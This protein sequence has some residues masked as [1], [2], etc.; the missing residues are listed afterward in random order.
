MKRSASQWLPLLAL[1]VPLVAHTND[2]PRELTALVQRAFDRTLHA[3]GVRSLELHV[4]RNGHL[5]SRRAFDLAYRRDASSARSLLRFTAPAYLRGHALLVIGTND[6]TS[7]TWLYQAEERRPRRIAATHKA[8]SFYGSDLSFE[9]LEHP[10]FEHWSL[11]LLEPEGDADSNHVVVEATPLRESQYGKL[12]VWIDRSREAVARVDFHRSA[13]AAPH[14]R[15]RISLDDAAEEDGFLRIAHMRIEQLGR[16]AWTDVETARMSVV[17]AIP[18]E[19]FSAAVLER[20]GDDL[21]ALVTR[22]TPS[23]PTP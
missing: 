6:G 20:E 13:D 23:E 19:I 3:P 22:R 2:A 11:R 10:R 14:K 21:H 9:E 16:D 18:A 5:V 15:L 8:D 1:L 12:V 17:P 7:D 4:H